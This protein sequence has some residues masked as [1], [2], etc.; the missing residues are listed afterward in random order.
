M[1]GLFNTV[2]NYADMRYAD[3]TGNSI[4]SNGDTSVLAIGVYKCSGGTCSDSSNMLKTDGLN[5]KV[6]CLEDDASCALNGEGTRKGMEVWGTGAGTLTL[7]A[8]TFHGET[9]WEG[10]GVHIRD[11][12]KVTIE[13]CVFSNCRST[14]SSDYG[15]GA[16]FVHSSGTTVNVYGTT[17][18]GNTAATGNGDDIYRDSGAITIHN[19]C[20]SP[21]SSNTPSQGAFK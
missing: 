2:S 16:I 5:G 18:N 3:N 19:T 15:G 9:I 11:G 10:G 6:K 4:M 1:N 13:L 8:L 14:R 17:F 21:Y 12:A 7:R 20:P